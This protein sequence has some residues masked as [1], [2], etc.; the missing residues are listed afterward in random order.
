MDFATLQSRLAAYIAAEQSILSGSQE[1]QVGQGSTA[2]RLRRADL[3]E[4]RAEIKA[5]SAQ[6]NAHPDNPAR[7]RRGIVYLRPL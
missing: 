4:I 6:V 5:L 2:R 7:P 1:Y 3:A